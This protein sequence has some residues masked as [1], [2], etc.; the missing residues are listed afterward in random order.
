M[1]FQVR[2]LSRALQDVDAI[3]DWIANAQQSPQGAA[4][5]LHA[6]EAAL[7]DLALTPYRHGLAPENQHVKIELRQFLFKT[8]AGRVYRG[9]FTIDGSEILVLR[10]RGPGQAPLESEDDL[11]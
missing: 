9:L 7:A 10:I 3:V 2:V 11:S 4:N 5:W 6:Y 1:T 8:R